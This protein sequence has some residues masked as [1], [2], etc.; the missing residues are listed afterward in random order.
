MEQRFDQ[1][2]RLPRPI[3]WLTDNGSCFP[4]RDTC[5]FAR[6]IGLIPHTTP[7]ESSQS[8]GMAEALVRLLK[9]DY[10]RVS[11]KPNARSVLEQLPSW[12]A[13]YDTIHPHRALGYRSPREYITRS[14]Q[15]ALS[16]L[17]GQ[18]QGGAAPAAHQTHLPPSLTRS[19]AIGC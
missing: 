2:N 15:E 8:N 11:S 17:P 14:T 7:I 1:V 18:Q 6:E 12:T 13:H 10:V 9:R 4:V 5:R 19:L 16:G 3:E